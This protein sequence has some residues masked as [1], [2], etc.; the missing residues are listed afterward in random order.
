MIKILKNYVFPILLAIVIFLIVPKTLTV[1]TVDGQSMS[2]NLAN[3]QH[4]WVNLKQPIQRGDVIVFNAIKED[5]GATANGADHKYYVKRV[6]AIAGDTVSNTPTGLYV[7]GK[8]VNE[9]YIDSVQK[10]QNTGYWTLDSLSK[11]PKQV[12][13][14]TYWNDPVVT[15]NKVPVGQI[16]VMGDNRLVSEDS[17]FFGFVSVSHV[18][19]VAHTLPFSEEGHIQTINGEVAKTYF[20]AK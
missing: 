10:G 7:N 6:I 11:V 3:G 5:P 1:A 12:G 9:S 18:L 4:I 2:P 20:S 8:L 14:D 19:G 15:N 16:F 17:R 13:S